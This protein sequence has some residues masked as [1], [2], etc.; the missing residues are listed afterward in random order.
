M[1][2]R[3]PTKT[4][5]KEVYWEFGRGTMTT[6]SVA[7]RRR[8]YMSF[9]NHHR[10]NSRGP[11]HTSED[12]D[13]SAFFNLDMILLKSHFSAILTALQESQLISQ[14]DKERLVRHMDRPDFEKHTAIVW[15]RNYTRYIESRNLT[16]FLSSFMHG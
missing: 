16:V 13:S 8:S 1:T 2:S 14:L 4:P 5:F 12:A 3:D 15:M 6:S 7:S 11:N 9:S 10:T